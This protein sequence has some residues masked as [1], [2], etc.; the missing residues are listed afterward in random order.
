MM[1]R[2]KGARTLDPRSES[3]SV[4]P[5]MAMGVSQILIPF[6]HRTR[7]VVMSQSLEL[8]FAGHAGA[9]IGAVCPTKSS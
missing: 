4:M 9:V 5:G 6:L 1:I 3:R 8:S 2:M 7:N